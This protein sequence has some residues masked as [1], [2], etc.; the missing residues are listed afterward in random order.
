VVSL[1]VAAAAAASVALHALVFWSLRRGRTGGERPAA[2]PIVVELLGSEPRGPAPRVADHGP[3]ASARISTPHE[4]RWRSHDPHSRP[5]E[6]PPGE[7]PPATRMPPSAAPP[8]AIDGRADALP[9]MTASGIDL[10][11]HTPLA[12][13]PTPGLNP[14][15]SPV[16]A[17]PPIEAPGTDVE[18]A[19]EYKRSTERPSRL[20]EA[21]EKLFAARA[22]PEPD[23][24]VKRRR[25]GSRIYHDQRADRFDAVMAPD[26]TLAFDDHHIH[27]RSFREQ[28]QKWLADPLHNA[29]PMPSLLL[30]FDATDEIMR[31]HGEDPYAAIKR[32]LLDDTL[33]ERQRLAD[34]HRR[35]TL[36]AA[37]AG[38]RPLVRAL[39]A[40]PTRSI[41]E[42]RRLLKELADECD[43]TPGG[44]IAR[45]IIAESAAALER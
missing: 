3:R 19:L 18:S 24:A 34:Q 14:Y 10:R 9:S 38:L 29:P 28:W 27:A 13:L 43:D 42:K 26:G 22:Q 21:W 40:D 16:H 41:S 2:E 7:T 32:K 25:D 20:P 23:Y 33:P 15:A 44:R 30:G 37:L 6:A 17:A 12:P 1:R 45:D 35:E 39:L 5:P 36:A 4:P 31:A 11:L 8:R